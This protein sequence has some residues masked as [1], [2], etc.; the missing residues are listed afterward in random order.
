LNDSEDRN[1]D[2]LISD[3]LDED[4]LKLFKEIVK[5]KGDLEK[6]VDDV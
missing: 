1:F 6:K 3:L 2:K 5:N 4:E